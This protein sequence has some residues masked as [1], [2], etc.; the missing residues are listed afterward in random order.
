MENYTY[1]DY[2]HFH[3][4]WAITQDSRGIIYVGN[5]AG[6]LEFDGVS[7]RVIYVPN[8][9]VR[10]LAIDETGTIYIGGNNEIGFFTPDE[11]G[12]LKYTSL[13]G[14]LNDNQKNFSYVRN[15]HAAKDGIYF[16]S[17]KFIFRWY[18]GKL[19]V[20][21]A[22]QKFIAS[23]YCNGILYI[24]QENV[25][26]LK[27]ENDLLKKIPGGDFFS[28]AEIF[29]MAPYDSNGDK[30]LIATRLKGLYIYEE[31]A[32][33]IVPFPTEVDIYLK[34]KELYQGIRLSSGDFALATLK[35]GLVIIDSSGRLKY[36]FDKSW[37][38]Q[39]E[40]VKHV[41]QDNQ[42]NLWLPLGNGISK[43][44]YASPFVIYGDQTGLK[45][46]VL[47]VT[48]HQTKLYAGTTNG[49]FWLTSLGKFNQVPP[50]S[51]PCW[52][53]LSINNSLLAVSDGGLFQIKWL[54][55]EQKNIPT[56]ILDYR[57]L[58]LL[59]S[60]KDANRI[61]VGTRQGL[62]SLY[63]DNVTGQ[64]QQ[65]LKFKNIN[66]EIYF[67][68]ETSNGAL[69][70]SALT[71]GV[72]KVDF[73]ADISNPIISRYDTT[74][75]LASMSARAFP[76][77]GHVMF[78]TERGIFRFDE[79]EKVFVPDKTL[80]D[81]F[82]NGSAGVFRIAEDNNKN[83]WIHSK[84]RNIQAILQPDGTVALKR[85][86]FLRMPIDQVN[87]IYPDPDGEKTWFAACNNLFCYH[88]TVEKNYR[89]NFSTLIR[90]V[91]LINR[92]FLIF[93]GYHVKIDQNQKA[94][95]FN[96]ILNYKDRNLRFQF[97][98][99][100]FEAETSTTYQVF[101]DGYDD[102]WSQWSSETQKDY[103][104]L[105]ADNYTFHV[106][107]KN[108]YDNISR[109]ASYG[110]RIL[111]PWYKTWWAFC[112]YG[113]TALFMVYLVVRWRSRK[114]LKEKQHLAQI[115]EDRT[116]EIREKNRQL[117]EQSEKLKEMDKVKSRFFA[118]ISHEFRTPLTLIMGPLE[119]VLSTK[120][121]PNREEFEKDAKVMLR[122]SQRLLHMVNQLLDLSKFESGQ[123]KLQ[124]SPGNLVPFL[125][126]M[127]ASFESKALQCKLE[128]TLQTQQEEILLYFDADKL[129]KVMVNLLSNAIK[130]TPA[131]G[132]VTVSAGKILAK[133]PGFPHGFLE[134]SVSDTGPG[135]PG[136]QLPRIFD[137]FYQASGSHE[138]HQKGSGIGLALTKEL[139]KL[140]HGTIE[141]RNREEKGSEFIIRLPRGSEHLAPDEI[142]EP[143]SSPITPPA[144][145][146]ISEKIPVLEKITEIEERKKEIE[147]EPE[148][149]KTNIILVV[150][151][152]GDMRDYIRRGLEP[153][154]TVL[155]AIDGQE[156]IQKARQII[157]D[158]IISDVMMPKVDGYEL[159]SVLKS[160]VKTSHIPIVLLTAK[161]SEENILQGLETGADDYIT[162]PFN[163]KILM[164]RIKNLIDIRSQLQMNVNREMTLQPIKTSVSK[165]DQEFLQDLHDVINKN[166]SDED[167]NVE[168]LCKKL[169]MGRTT[170]YRKVLAL[171]GETPTDFIRSYR[172]KR[173]AELLKQTFGTVLEVA[174]EVGFSNSSYFAKCFKEKFHQLPSEYQAANKQ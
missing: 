128:L 148:T 22:N 171:T 2:D 52:S 88:T 116:R 119:K 153:D 29:M 140:H 4:N 112:I 62:I 144:Q 136:D 30:L 59:R 107:A 13:K 58:F 103:T 11:K 151:D 71:K 43:I 47:S 114:L 5:N 125:K 74:H 16:E 157:P 14:H 133:V 111:P 6:L 95:K 108:V 60:K 163:T 9:S 73:T 25:G 172:L 139:V 115:I 145:G 137:R 131:G 26:I 150:E 72:I 147:P 152:S 96:P 162:K 166:L 159:C 51:D 61:W 122:S 50:I 49:L 68:V 18:S 126:T 138:H 97:A 15:T 34:K 149:D 24:Q 63:L 155:E 173:A 46:T 40:S 154:Y 66:Q 54:P 102:D 77:A 164:A 35:G 94:E 130:F 20:W 17:E 127:I 90:K 84:G 65:E 146:S 124:T 121:D 10:S 21:E 1:E 12:T 8:M 70:L 120:D 83:I 42:G 76:A 87:S 169:Y 160:D 67:I 45:G 57:S 135:I 156:G 82:S 89:Q 158:L 134:I 170:L 85:K 23:S 129:E 3:Q 78:A 110:F 33:S 142:I 105:D 79:D 19:Y 100:F 69:W 38:L 75:G 123:M 168:Q 117:E 80:G 53:L 36:L 37:G 132:K 141:A 86:P 7:W 118:N 93:D 167:F 27:M 64:W 39:D 44:E 174:F 41:F 28:D 55:K 31:N 48:K 106:R 165:I 109:E 98:A 143:S 56:K 81:E 99:P 104:N 161:A 92:E 32:N 101:L 91:K 113:F